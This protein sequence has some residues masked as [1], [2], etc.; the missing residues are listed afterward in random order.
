VETTGKLLPGVEA[1][2]VNPDT[3]E[4]MLPGEQGELWLKSPT[5]MKGN[6]WL[7]NCV[8]NGFLM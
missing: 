6:V 8:V 4:A 7:G 2:I 3:G 1:K 5:I